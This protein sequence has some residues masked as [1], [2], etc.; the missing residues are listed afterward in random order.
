MQVSAA[1]ADTSY[2][3][4]PSLSLDDLD[5]ATIATDQLIALVR[6][7]REGEE[8]PTAEVLLGNLPK[9]LRAL[10]D[11]LLSGEATALDVA[12]RIA[13]ITDIV[14]RVCSRNG[15]NR[16]LIPNTTKNL[17]YE[18]ADTMPIFCRASRIKFL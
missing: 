17:L 6:S 18:T 7:H 5:L 12:Y 3:A 10:C 9:V 15:R 16:T 13:S 8:Y 14:F 1:V 11:Y 2:P 4:S